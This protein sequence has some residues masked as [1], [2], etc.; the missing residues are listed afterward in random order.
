MKLHKSLS[1]ILVLEKKNENF[2]VL[3]LKQLPSLSPA[4]FLLIVVLKFVVL[5]MSSGI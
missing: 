3:F 4:D 2:R 1:L 5:F